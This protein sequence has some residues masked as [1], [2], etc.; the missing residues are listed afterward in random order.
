MRSSLVPA[1]VYSLVDGS[2]SDSPKHPGYFI[3][4]VFLWNPN[5]LGATI[6]PPKP[7]YTPVCKHNRAILIL[8]GICA[9]P[10]DGSQVGLVIARPFSQSALFSI[11]AFL[12]DR[13][14][15]GLKVLYMS[16]CFYSSIGVH[17]RLQ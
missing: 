15:F 2:V 6:F 5:P 8:S 12:V 3:L 13:I 10:W 11:S 9:C 17:A 4:M 7:C 14:N 16:W 1:H